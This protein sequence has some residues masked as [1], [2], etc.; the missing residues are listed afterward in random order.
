MTKHTA[1]RKR[2]ATE[3]RILRA[4]IMDLRAAGFALSTE[5]QDTG[6]TIDFAG[7]SVKKIMD[8]M[9]ACDDGRLYAT[10]ADFQKTQWVYFV[11]G[12]DGWDVIS[13]YS[14]PLEPFLKRADAISDK[15]QEA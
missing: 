6:E 2:I 5:D 13:D 12:N 9:T 1:T 10:R 11:Y 3:R 4:V 7:Q 8:E 14:V 15:A